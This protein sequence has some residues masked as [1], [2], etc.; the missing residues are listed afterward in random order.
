[1]LY[2]IF[3]FCIILVCFLNIYYTFFALLVHSSPPH[4]FPTL[5]P[6][7]AHPLPSLSGF[8]VVIQPLMEETFESSG[9]LSPP[10]Q[11]NPARWQRLT[12]CSWRESG[13]LEADQTAW[14]SGAEELPPS[15]TWTLRGDVASGGP[16]VTVSLTH[17]QAAPLNHHLKTQSSA[18]V[19]IKRI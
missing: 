15:A 11:L 3:L 16:L 4:S 6:T 17:M 19:L 13:S 5:C 10:L 2:S 7:H 18:G 9:G 12:R 8:Q 14:C 1:M